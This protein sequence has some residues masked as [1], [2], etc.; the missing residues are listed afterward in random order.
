MLYSD[1]FDSE[2]TFGNCSL[3]MGNSLFSIRIYICNTG[4][5][6]T[7]SNRKRRNIMHELRLLDI[8]KNIKIKK[9][10]ENLIIHLPMVCMDFWEKMVREKQH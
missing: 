10:L 3:D 1:W 8:Q 2:N 5:E 9:Q 6:I 7:E 4:K